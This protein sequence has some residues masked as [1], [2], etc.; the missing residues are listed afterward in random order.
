MSTLVHRVV[1]PPGCG[2]TTWLSRQCKRAVEKYGPDS[3][4]VVSLTR[5]AALEAAGRDTGL[6]HE[7][8]GT[9]HSHCYKVIGRPKLAE[10]PKNLKDW[11]AE[12]PHLA[13]GPDDAVEWADGGRSG[14]DGDFLMAE[15]NLLR[16]R[17]TPPE[18]WPQPVKDF[19]EL[20]EDYKRQTGTVD[21]CGMIERAVTDAPLP[22]GGPSVIFADEAQDFSAL[23]LELLDR[24]GGKVE[25]LTLVYDPAQA[26]Y[27]WRGADPSTASATPSI[28][29]SQSYRVPPTVQEYALSLVRRSS[30]YREA[31]YA[32]REGEDGLVTRAPW[33]AAEPGPWVEELDD[34]FSGTTMVL[35][36]CGFTLNR[37]VAEMRSRGVPYH[38]PYSPQRWNPLRAGTKE[39]VTA[40]D[41][42]LAFASR[43]ERGNLQKRELEF[44]AESLTAPALRPGWRDALARVPD[45]PT[46]EEL[47]RHELRVFSEDG[48]GALARGDLEWYA[49]TLKSQHRKSLDYPMAVLRRCG[50][51]ALREVS[52]A[53]RPVKGAVVVG[54]V[55]SVKGGEADRV[56]LFPDMSLRGVKSLR[57]PG[58]MHHDAVWRTFYVAATRA[59]SELVLCEASRRSASC[60]L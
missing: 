5:A 20:W 29:L 41:R 58:W 23:E 3:A 22:P 19:A 1:G 47:A 51:R 26:L 42:L 54:T 16:H 13:V 18:A 44:L 48:A 38:N 10:D 6:S 52:V 56:V 43:P 60:P 35:A 12:H 45:R 31:E 28:V 9:L 21:F 49:A 15:L 30:T 2:K 55:H 34:P 50:E 27:G 57:T 4:L 32:P 46:P 24:W 53:D 36:S 8:V 40:V 33:K 39:R 59:K 7:M 17:L 11:N 14:S 25:H 37:L